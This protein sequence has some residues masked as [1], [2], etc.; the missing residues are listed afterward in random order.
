MKHTEIQQFWNKTWKKKSVHIPK[1]IIFMC[2]T[3][4]K[5]SSMLLSN[6]YYQK[7][8]NF[9][10]GNLYFFRNTKCPQNNNECGQHE[11]VNCVEFNVST[12]HVT[13]NMNTKKHISNVQE[14]TWPHENMCCYVN[15]LM[16]FQLN[17]INIKKRESWP[18]SK[19]PSPNFTNSDLSSF[20][21]THGTY[22]LNVS[23]QSVN[24]PKYFF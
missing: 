22:F 19:H 12:V 8:W 16:T 21:L 5:D 4:W 11:Q 6:H 20:I 1:Y 18:S 13:C 17:S 10:V 2:K 3:Q 15:V 7:S 24:C 23:Y 14:Q 9:L